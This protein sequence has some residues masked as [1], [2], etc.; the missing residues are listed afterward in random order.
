MITISRLRVLVAKVRGLFGDREANPD[1]DAEMREHLSLLTDSY[2]RQGATPEDAVRAARRQFGNTTSLQENRRDMQ[3]IPTLESIWRDVCHGGRMLR[4]NPGLTTAVVLTLA[5][6]IGANTAI[7]SVCNAILLQPFPYSDPERVV[8]LWEQL[9]EK[10]K[11]MSAAPA[12]FLDWRAQTR[13]FSEMAA[14]N[15]FFSF[16]LSGRGEPARLAA[17]GV[18][19]NLFSLLGTRITMGRSFLPE[20]DQ[21]G[22]DHVAILS[23]RTWVNHFGAQLDILGKNVTF[24][25]VSYTVVGVLPADF[26]FVSRSSDYTSRTDFDSRNQFDIWVPLALNLE[27][28]QRNTHPLRVVARLRPGITLSQAQAD[29]NVVAANLAQAY[30]ANDKGM[31]IR[32]VP[33][34]QQVTANVRPGLLTLLGAAGFVLLIACANVAN[35]LL[36]RAAARQKEI[37]VRVAMGASHRRVAQQLLIESL[38]LAFAGGAMGLLLAAAAI[39][40]AEPFLPADLSRASGIGLDGRV[41][42]FSGLISLATGVLFGMA[43]LLQA[44]R[45]NANESLKQGARI[46]RGTQSGLRGGLVVGQIAIALVLLVGAG[47]M[48]K[49]FWALLHVQPGFRTDH[50]LTARLTMSQSSYPNAGK[51]GAFQR[52]LLE[53]VRNIPGVQSAGLAT[54]LPLSGTDNGWSFLIEGRPPL[55]I[56][57][58]NMAKYRPVSPGYF[59][60]IG[61][62]LL[63]GRGLRSADNESAPFVV[64]INEY[65]ARTYWG[66]QNPVGQRLKFGPETW[67]TVIGVAGD[68][69]HEGLD[70]ELKPEM[71][72]PFAQAPNVET[73]PTI[74]V[75]TQIDAASMTM[76]LR[77]T[78][79]AM[80]ATVPLDQVETMEQ[81]V[82]TSVG[83]P[84]FRTVLLAVFSMLALVMAS[85][86]IY[87]VMNYSVMQRTREFGI[88]LAV[89][90]TQRDVLG[91][92]LGRAAVLIGAGLG[93]GLLAAAM[94]TRLIATL[95][96]GVTALDPLTFVVVPLVL[97]VVALVASYIPARR[98]TRVDPMIAL[99]CE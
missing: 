15:P 22:H 76:S 8:M 35:L 68:V 67:R 48:V 95:L 88:C 20:E 13:S 11:L 40:A 80:D 41:L 66:Q 87:G 51:I 28:P 93:L 85:I 59:E 24:S 23:Y 45:V 38:L 6:G 74:V 84:R 71:Y 5:L 43:P 2:I 14:L 98:A 60:T 33:L 58:H 56:G 29:L 50:L 94:L 77:K 16:I 30:P 86:G 61:M 21:P 10:G 81:L 70:G 34:G 83:Q 17:A 42:V 52:E 27:R 54:Y 9:P 3:T 99:R 78:V 62:P 64:V 72:V 53:R 18:S 26:E 90:A 36:C 92:V 97:S 39:R 96:Y 89:G 19:S 65:M 82:S 31:G 37:A 91:R 75:R 1:F 4:K 46:A 47:L 12:N 55:P 57:V 7:F 73:E 69:R 79:F 44:R 63:R 32:A 49:S 25:D